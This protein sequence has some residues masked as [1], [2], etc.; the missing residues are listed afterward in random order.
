[1]N[2]NLIK[3]RF[4]LVFNDDEKLQD[5]ELDILSVSF[6]G[7]TLSSYEVPFRSGLKIKK[8]GDEITFNTL[9]ITFRVTQD[10]QNYVD[11]L[12]WIFELKNPLTGIAIEKH[13]PATLQLYLPTGK[14]LRE[15][16]FA[17]MF[18]VSLSDIQ[19]STNTDDTEYQECI[20]GF[21]YTY[22]EF[23]NKQTILN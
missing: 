16:Y 20:V 5:L 11:L 1:M 15:I 6:P 12:E 17:G 22:F 9:S 4:K 19:F 7:I 18:P 2:S 21:E 8:S 23:G 10:L 13:L 3:N 14:L